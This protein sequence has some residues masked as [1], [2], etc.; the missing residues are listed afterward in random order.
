MKPF[1]RCLFILPLL[2]AAFAFGGA[3]QA[4]TGTL[5]PAIR[6]VTWT[7]IAIQP[8]AG[9]RQDTTGSGI[10]IQFKDEG[11]FVGTSTCNSYGGHYQVGANQALTVTEFDS[12]AMACADQSRMDRE[13]T[14]FAALRQIA[15]YQLDGDTLRLTFNGQATLEFRATAPNAT[16]SADLW[17]P[18]LLVLVLVAAGL[19]WRVA[20]QAR[21]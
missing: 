16:P 10:T 20:V 13:T 8:A 6:G 17:L 7:L 15:A 12:T 9:T 14:Y 1:G 21:R 19:G 2:A 4:Q 5:P 3:A 11:S 18:G